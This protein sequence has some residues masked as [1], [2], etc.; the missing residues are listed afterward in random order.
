MAA[1]DFPTSPAVNDIYTSGNKSWRWDGTTWTANT[2]GA[3]IPL[4][5]GVSGV[6][7][8][9]NGGTGAAGGGAMIADAMVA[10]N[11]R[12]GAF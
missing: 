1:L 3:L 4:A 6:L 11:I 5:S 7:P 12:F 2:S 9:T 10:L 8:L